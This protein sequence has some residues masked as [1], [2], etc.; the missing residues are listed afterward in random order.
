[1]GL[2]DQFKAEAD[3]VRRQLAEKAGIDVDKLGAQASQLGQKAKA[4]A[5]G[6]R[7][8]ATDQ[9]NAYTRGEAVA[10]TEEP[11]GLDVGA[12]KAKAQALLGEAKDRAAAARDKVAES[13]DAAAVAVAARVSA[14]TGREVTPSQ[15]KKVALALGVTLL[16]AGAIE[17]ISEAVAQGGVEGAGLAEGAS[18]A[19][20]E[21]AS[22]AAA[23]SGDVMDQ[24]HEFFA[25]NGSSLNIETVT[26][27]IDG[28]EI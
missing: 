21:G 12:L 17:L 28:C 20:A 25:R 13:T 3:K 10:P 2:F 22:S 1:M 11:G 6:L 16:A 27:D 4:Q 24:A 9:V 5:Q 8:K 23:G 19:A 7:Q 18:G 26:V 14:K 15:V